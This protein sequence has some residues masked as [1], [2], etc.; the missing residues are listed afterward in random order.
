MTEEQGLLSS[1]IFTYISF[2]KFDNWVRKYLMS[3]KG[4]YLRNKNVLHA[5]L[6]W[7]KPRQTFGKIWEQISENP[8]CSFWKQGNIS[9]SISATERCRV[10]IVIKW[11]TFN[12][13]VFLERSVWSELANTKISLKFQPSNSFNLEVL[14]VVIRPVL[15]FLYFPI[16]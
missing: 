12:L 13:W 10:V 7:W 5:V 14:K 11:L 15:R 9:G 3:W 2:E 16:R 8:R 6:A 1:T 4:N